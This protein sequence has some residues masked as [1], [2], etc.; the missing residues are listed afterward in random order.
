MNNAFFIIDL[1][2]T[3]VFAL[4]GALIGVKQ[5][6]DIFGIF[7]L[8]F[9][10]AIGGGILRDICISATPPAGLISGEYLICTIVAVFL[11]FFFQNVIT[12][13]EKLSNFFDAAGLGFF[14]AFGA[15]KTYQ[16]T[17][18]IQLSIILGCISAIGGGIIRDLLSNRKPIVFNQ[19]LYASAALIG[20]SI[21]VL[22]SSGVINNQISMVLAVIVTITI[23]MFALKY[24]IKLPS[25]KSS[26]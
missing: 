7:V 13:L 9:I 15:N 18:N 24:N 12:S 19:E 16:Y 4:S 8:A 22:G 21:E 26:E 17:H 23:R 14:A 5:N 11:V 3:F 1:L 10:T 6:F 20:A 2:G 25:T